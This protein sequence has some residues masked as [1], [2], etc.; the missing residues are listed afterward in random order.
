MLII[1]DF[2]CIYCEHI[3]ERIVDSETEWVQCP[4]CQHAEGAHKIISVGRVHC[5]NEDTA[6][7]KT[8]REVVDK[9]GGPASQ[10]FLKN[11]TRTNYKKWMEENNLRPL[12]PGERASKPAPPDEDRLTQKLFERRRERNRLEVW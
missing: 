12:E 3:H 5:G 7:L 9:D 10:E 11:P 8:V 2:E 4:K 1:R 6:W